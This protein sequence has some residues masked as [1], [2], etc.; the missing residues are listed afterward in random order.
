MKLSGFKASLKLAPAGASWQWLAALLLTFGATVT[1]LGGT[2]G[3]PRPVATG[4]TA[5]ET[6][7]ANSKWARIVMIGASASAG[8]T[9]SEP[10]GGTN[11]AKV[12]L[13]RYLDAAVLVPHEPVSNLANAL[14][15]LA[16]EL[17]GR[18]QIEL[19][20]KARP[21]L[22]VGADFLFW[23]CYGDGS[24]DDERLQHFEQGLE[25]LEEIP[26]PL[27]VGDIPDCSAA[28]DDML[29]PDELPSATAMA[30]ANR[31]L[32]QWAASRPQVTILPL[33]SFMRSVMANQALSIHGYNL[34]AGKT[35]VLLQNDKL[36]PSPAGCAVLAL[37]ILDACSGTRPAASPGDV[38]WNPQDI[39]RLVLNP[40]P[41]LVSD[42][43]SAAGTRAAG[44]SPPASAPAGH[45]R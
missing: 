2:Q 23:F 4:T 35:R 31:R 11:T 27:V 40:P 34:P 5:V 12:R 9:Q 18:S 44:P 8:F 14:F 1:M 29:R 22:V 25:L 38:R 17:A 39:S 21:T 42:P 19:A 45:E 28:V 20:L 41:H 10:F 13:S 37:F 3:P 7:A 16:P 15:F 26:C 6:R 33:S 43:A 36:H 32:N 30:A 24:T